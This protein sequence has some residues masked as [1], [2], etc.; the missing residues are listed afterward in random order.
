M[1]EKNYRRFCKII[2]ETPKETL[3]KIADI[4]DGHSI[5][6]Q[7]T[8]LNAGLHPDIVDEFAD[9]HLSDFRNPK[10]TIFSTRT[11]EAVEKMA[12][13]Y[14]LEII[15][16]IARVFGISSDKNGRGFR[17]SDLKQQLHALFASTPA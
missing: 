12:G 17:A 11:G 1:T 15:E 9:C 3:L 8:F 4:C 7:E 2:K 14:G 10:E 5:F 6:T 13:I 16:F